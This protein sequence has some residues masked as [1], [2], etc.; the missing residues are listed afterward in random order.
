[1][2]DNFIVVQKIGNLFFISIILS[3]GFILNIYIYIYDREDPSKCNFFHWA[4]QPL[5]PPIISTYQQAIQVD[6]SNSKY[7]RNNNDRK[8]FN[9][10]NQSMSQNN[11]NNNNNRP[12]SN[13]SRADIT[14]SYCKQQ[15]HYARECPNK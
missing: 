5:P 12:T 8:S 15:G 2:E 1:M 4:D 10:G 9:R 3:N 7:G 13:M 11:N 14:C 6:N